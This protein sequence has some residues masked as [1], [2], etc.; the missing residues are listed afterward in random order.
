MKYVPVPRLVG[1][2]RRTLTHH[3]FNESNSIGLI[4]Y[5]GCHCAALALAS[6]YNHAALAGLVFGQATVNA[7]FDIVGRADVAANVRAINLD[8][9]GKGVALGFGGKGLTKL[10]RQPEGGKISWRQRSCYQPDNR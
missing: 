10:V 8:F 3:A 1:M 2:D 5:Y 7:V 6:G 9:T 4:A